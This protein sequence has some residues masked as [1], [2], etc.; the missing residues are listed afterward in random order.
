MVLSI[1][2][3]NVTVVI[4]VSLFSFITFRTAPIFPVL[5]CSL[6][7]SLFHSLLIILDQNLDALAPVI[8]INLRR[9]HYADL[10]LS[11]HQTS[12]EALYE[13]FLS[14]FLH[15][16]PVHFF[17]IPKVYRLIRISLLIRDPDSTEFSCA[18][19]Q[20]AVSDSLCQMA[21]VFPVRQENSGQQA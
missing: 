19:L 17:S 10:H 8:G 20:K 16:I 14:I 18:S 21:P 13:P 12:P 6:F 7:G 3:F 5:F 11:L 2:G 9:V 4:I 15:Q 1:A